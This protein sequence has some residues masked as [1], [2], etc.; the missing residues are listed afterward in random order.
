[1]FL[2]SNTD[3]YGS[4]MLRKNL[5]ILGKILLQIFSNRRYCTGCYGEKILIYRMFEMRWI[6]PLLLCQSICDRQTTIAP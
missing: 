1:M 6:C 5:E 2:G 4:K 3:V